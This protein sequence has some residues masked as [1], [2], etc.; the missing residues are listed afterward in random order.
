MCFH[1]RKDVRHE[2][3]VGKVGLDIQVSVTY[4]TILDTASCRCY[5]ITGTSKLICNESAGART[6]AED[7]DRGFGSHV[8]VIGFEAFVRERECVRKNRYLKTD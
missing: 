2:N 4:R 3:R 7:E 6:N 1:F 8:K 5:L